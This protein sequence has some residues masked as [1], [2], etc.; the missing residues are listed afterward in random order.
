M[1]HSFF[2]LT[3]VM[4]FLTCIYT[5]HHIRQIIL[6]KASKHNTLSK[7]LLFFAIYF[8]LSSSIFLGFTEKL[9]TLLQN[10][11]CLLW[12]FYFYFLMFCFASDL[13]LGALLIVS[14]CKHKEIVTEKVTRITY[15][16]SIFTCIFFLT[17]GAFYAKI[18]R[19]A[20]YDVTI[21]SNATDSQ[22]SLKIV[23]LSD[24]HIGK[25]LGHTQVEKWVDKINQLAPDMVCICGDIFND[26]LYDVKD[27][28]K[29]EKA[30]STINSKY[31]TFS[32]L[33]NHDTE[34]I[35][36]SYGNVTSDAMS[37]FNNSN[38]TLL[39]DEYKLID[40]LFYIVGRSDASPSMDEANYSSMELSDI[41][42]DTNP[43]IPIIL[44]DHRPQRFDEAK[45][46]KVSLLLAGHTHLGQIF[47]ANI[48]TNITYECDY[49]I[50]TDY[51]E[52]SSH[53]FTAI[54][55]SGL[56]YWGP[57]LRIGSSCELVVVNLTIH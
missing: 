6:P 35:I 36:D 27:L 21:D 5:G 56:G 50:Y 46:N 45:D 17:I 48:L 19:T 14:T 51:L 24:T 30:L 23:M 3:I 11:G 37:F 15:L 26:S 39:Y 12:G 53:N 52:A 41:L 13:F 47:P 10:F 34:G 7:K 22:S 38:I 32:C 18:T 4:Y 44:L 55:S 28:D 29:I 57:P 40:N 2:S 1:H 54:V 9:G 42:K 31:G 25:Q 33:G 49:G 8:I 43:D 20:Q 16:V